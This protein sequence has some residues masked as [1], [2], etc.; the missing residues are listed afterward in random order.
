M[1]SEILS[2]LRERGDYVSGQELCKRFGVS[3]TAVWKAVN[4]LKKE[5]YAIEAVPNRGYLLTEGTELYGKNELE[6]RMET[7][8]AGRR[9][10]FFDSLNS[11][12]L[13][14]KQE[15]ENGAAQGTVVVADMQ[16]AGRGRRG[17][18][19]SS[20]PGTNVYF[21]L[22]LKPKYEPDKASMVTLVMALAVAAGIRQTCGAQALIKWPNDIVIDGKKVC[23]ILTEM[24]VE[25]DYIH[26]VVSGVGIN[27]GRQEFPPE[28]AATAVCLEEVCGEKV[29]RAALIVNV[30]RYFE[31]YYEKFCERT[32]LSGVLE[33]YNRL[34]INRD[35]EICV[36]DP[37]GNYRGISKGINSVGEL[38]VELED[39][40]T[41]NV[42][43]GE[44]S[45]RGVYGYT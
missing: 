15:A 20:P 40:S 45:V 21:T 18:S 27:V 34:L 5:G 41:V 23:G 17:R 3:R 14:A 42:Y 39:G 31:E 24:S 10:L 7:V 43:A 33:D 13:R 44:V 36:L 26:Y 28:I 30:M 6:S 11:T 8:W 19:W 37:K 1:K 2:L 22:I 16:T 35:R 25:R 12:N 4:Q 38:L 32:D 9:V 29:S